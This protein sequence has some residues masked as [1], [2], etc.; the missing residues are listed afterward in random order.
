MDK[1]IFL[2]LHHVT[3]EGYEQPSTHQ[4]MPMKNESNDQ[5]PQE[6][7]AKDIWMNQGHAGINLTERRG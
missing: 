1:P 5:D 7:K 3:I 4:P 6:V 2:M